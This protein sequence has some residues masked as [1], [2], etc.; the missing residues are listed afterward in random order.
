MSDFSI[1]DAIASDVAAIEAC[2]DAAYRMYVDRMGK[3]PAPMLD[4][5]GELVGRGQVRVAVDVN[6][7]L[8]GLIVSWPEVDHLHVSNVVVD[9][10]AQG[11]GVGAVMIADVEASARR[12]QL[13]ELR[14]YTNVAMT[15]N[16][17]YYP[18][19]GFEETH[20]KH[21]DG[22]ER[23]FYRRSVPIERE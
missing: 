1:R 19:I 6:D 22:Y 5:Y 11:Q 13:Q 23:V 14:L 21:Q 15:E 16:L 3:P 7:A 17:T 12:Q 9:P 4:D 18:R 20:R 10:S 8:L 2:V